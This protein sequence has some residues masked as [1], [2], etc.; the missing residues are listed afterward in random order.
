M[1]GWMDGWRGVWVVFLDLEVE[2]E[3]GGGEALRV[4]TWN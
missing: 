3:F 4:D 2:G 1:D